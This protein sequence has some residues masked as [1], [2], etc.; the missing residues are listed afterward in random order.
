MKFSSGANNCWSFQAPQNLKSSFKLIKLKINSINI[1]KENEQMKDFRQTV[2]DAGNTI[3]S[4]LSKM[5]EKDVCHIN[6]N[7]QMAYS[8]INALADAG[9]GLRTHQLWTYL[10]LYYTAKAGMS[11]IGFIDANNIDCAGKD[12]S[13]GSS[14][15]SLI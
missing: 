11:A 2:V 9:L 1:G 7:A 10:L 13:E 4:N 8:G 5:S 15:C 12:S 3:H 14:N 6:K